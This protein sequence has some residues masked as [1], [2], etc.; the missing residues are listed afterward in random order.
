[1]LI[2]GCSAVVSRLAGLR[3]LHL[4][5]G[6]ALLGALVWPI[7][8]RADAF[9]LNDTTWEGCTELLALARAELGEERVIVRSV[10]DWREVQP[11]DGVLLIHPLRIVDPEEA[12]AFMRA[13]GRLA[14]VDDFGRGDR[15]LEHFRI[16]RR[17]L[18]ARPMRVL[19]KKPALP[20]ATPATDGD[21]ERTVGIH[22]T[23]AQVDR[24]MLNHGSGLSHPQLTPVLEVRAVG[25]P[26]VAVAVAGQVDGG[27]LFAMGDSSVFINLMLRYPGNRRFAAGLLR[28]LVEGDRPTAGQGRLYVLTNQFDERVG[29]GGVTPWRKSL[30]RKLDAVRDELAGLRHDGLPPWAHTLVAALVALL[31]LWWSVGALLRIYRSRLPRFARATPLVAQGGLAGRVAVLSSPT[32]PPALALLELRSALGESLARHLEEPPHTRPA[33]LVDAAVRHGEVDGDTQAAIRGALRQM[34]RAETGVVAGNPIRVTR[35]DVER[36]ARAVEQLL[37]Q[38]GA[39]VVRRRDDG[40]E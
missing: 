11:F 16:Q 40:P 14:V 25:E 35:A 29:F 22:P 9:D 12:T 28:Y 13:G 31:V 17:T 20:V 6:L 34:Q 8:A 4:L 19:R 23:V 5:T 30:H 18:P 24:V 10:L 37:V 33:K 3:L 26:S 27:R 39:D 7:R 1:M 36:A 21:A 2:R 15:L 38:I 32:S